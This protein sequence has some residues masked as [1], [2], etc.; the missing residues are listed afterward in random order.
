MIPHVNFSWL[1]RGLASGAASEA[2]LGVL[3]TR[4][5]GV[6]RAMPSLP[7]T[8]S[9]TVLQY[10]STRNLLLTVQAQFGGEIRRSEWLRGIYGTVD[11]ERHKR[12]F[13]KVW[14]PSRLSRDR[15]Q[16][17]VRIR[18]RGPAGDLVGAGVLCC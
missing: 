2:P 17:R 14:D 10:C 13:T 11:L 16:R 12:T 8:R 9:C 18:G 1:I 3:L 7:T 6:D 4:A 15:R 5:R